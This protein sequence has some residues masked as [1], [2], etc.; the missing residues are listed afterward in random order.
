MNSSA[1]GSDEM[2]AI[3]DLPD[4][5]SHEAVHVFDDRATG[6]KAVIAVHSTHLGPAA[7]GTRFWHYAGSQAA[8]TD[9]LGLSRGMS[10]KN[11]MAGLSAGGGKAVILANPQRAKPQE[12][13]E[14]FGRAVDSL[15][16]KYITAQDVGISEAD[17]VA[18]SKVTP[19]VAGLP[20]QG[21]DPGPY[22][23]R[24]V[25]LGVK[26]A[27]KH[28]LGT[29]DLKGGVGSVGC[30]LARYLAAE[31]AK[32]TLADVDAQRAADLAHELG[33]QNVAADAI[34]ALEA[35]VFSPCALGAVLTE[36]SVAALKVRAVAG[37]ANNQLATGAEGRML[38]DRG[39]LYAPDYVINAGGIINVL[40]QI[41][42]ADDAE[43]NRRVDGIAGRLEAIWIESDSTGKTP[44]EVADNM[45]QKLIG[46]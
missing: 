20:G 2:P 30:G 25:F 8:I 34:M 15:G 37:G 24:G 21:G 42:N 36:A 13:L 1:F 7:G 11:A 46:R 22:T 29:D 18:V 32:L 31:G 14:A 43:I 28:A 12:L 10:Y 17:M 23:A 3:W 26:A 6:L 35:D 39:I 38:A 41:E 44:A 19:H 5:D 16:G 4:F 27:V 33:A 45:A 9:A 40:R